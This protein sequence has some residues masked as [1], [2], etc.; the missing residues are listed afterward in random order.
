MKNRVTATMNFQTSNHF[1]KGLSAP[2]SPV[3]GQT[4]LKGLKEAPYSRI[5]GEVTHG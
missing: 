4:A 2:V 3:W 1:K 5:K